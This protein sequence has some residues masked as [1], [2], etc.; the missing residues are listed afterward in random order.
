VRVNYD[1]DV[2]EYVDAEAGEFLSNDGVEPFKI[3]KTGDGYV[4]YDTTKY[5]TAVGTSG[6][7]TLFTV[8]FRALSAGESEI[9]LDMIQIVG[10]DLTGNIDFEA[11]GGDVNVQ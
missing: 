6:S 10:D 8:E 5:M 4:K 1:K 9:T 3:V 2:L 11:V 7:G